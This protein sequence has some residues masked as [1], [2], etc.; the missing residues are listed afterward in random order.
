MIASGYL[1]LTR[2]ADGSVDTFIKQQKSMFVFFQGHPEYEADTLY[3]EYRRDIGR[4]LKGE[5]DYYPHMP[6]G[7]FD[8][9]MAE[10]L[11]AFQ[12]RALCDR[13]RELLAELPALQPSRITSRSPWR[14]AAVQIYG[15]WLADLCARKERRP[16][17]V[18]PSA[19]PLRTTWP[20]G[21]ASSR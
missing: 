5:T 16:T 18:G 2:L 19:P 14:S 4:Y 3:L 17:A 12:S 13:R 10:A 21:R 15:N 1:S 11:R 7:Y 8:Q 20:A 9:A 6:V